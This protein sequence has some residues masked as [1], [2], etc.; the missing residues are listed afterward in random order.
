MKKLLGLFIVSFYLSTLAIG[1]ASAGDIKADIAGYWPLDGNVK[2]QISG[3]EGKRVGGTNFVDGK[4]NKAVELDG[5]GYVQIDDFKLVTDN[6]TIT[7]W[8][9]GWKTTDWTGI[10]ASRGTSPAWVG[11][12]PSDT[13]TYVWNNDSPNTYSWVGGAPIAKD[14]WCFIAIAID[15]DKAISFTYTETDGPKSGENKLAHIEET[16]DKL[17]F[18]W[19]ECCGADRHFKGIIDEVMIF[20]RALSVDELTKLATTGLAVNYEGKLAATWGEVKI[21]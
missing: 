12:G 20:K 15:P 16:I 7:G 4:K 1:I 2:D 21:K 6:V 5:T 10:I 14:K 8:I 18:G 11:F 17:K 19:D 3:R 13:L 9:N